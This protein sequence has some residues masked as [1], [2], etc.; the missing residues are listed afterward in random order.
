MRALDVGTVQLGQGATQAHAI[1]SLGPSHRAD[2]PPGANGRSRLSG[3][4]DGVVLS[5]VL[6]PYSSFSFHLSY[7]LSLGFVQ[8]E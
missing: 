2:G 5:L 6:Q 4:R 8:T 1:C 7:F 3:R